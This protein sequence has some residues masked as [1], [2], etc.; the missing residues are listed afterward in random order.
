MAYY[1]TCP[2]CGSNLD[3]GEK[4][5]CSNPSQVTDLKFKEANAAP[6]TTRNDVLNQVS[7]PAQLSKRLYHGGVLHVKKGA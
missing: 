7:D 1:H 2:E 3:P 5:E 4:C 6:I